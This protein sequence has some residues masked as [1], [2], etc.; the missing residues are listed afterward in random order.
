M[1][2]FPWKVIFTLLLFSE[3]NP[4][5]GQGMRHMKCLEN[6]EKVA[7]KCGSFQKDFN[8]SSR[9]YH[10]NGKKLKS[11]NTRANS[12]CAA[13]YDKFLS[14]MTKAEK[15]YNHCNKADECLAVEFYDVMI[16]VNSKYFPKVENDLD[17]KLEQSSR[18]CFY[19]ENQEVYL[20]EY[21]QKKDRLEP[22]HY[23]CEKNIC[24][25]RFDGPGVSWYD[26]Y[27]KL[28]DAKHP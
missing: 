2:R 6:C 14:E 17:M 7:Q 21:V 23:T 20:F 26:V 22:T 16:H 10:C 15:K 11:L 3:R 12:K 28:R 18:K 1:K 5:Y 4:S 19:P 25:P 13:S 8:T 24:V 9:F 27:D